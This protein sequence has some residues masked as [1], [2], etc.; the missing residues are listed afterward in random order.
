MLQGY[1]QQLAEAMQRFSQQGTE[2]LASMRTANENSVRAMTGAGESM[3]ESSEQLSRSYQNFV[4]DVVEGLSRALGMFD[5]NM[6]CV[7]AALGDKLQGTS[8]AP[9]AEIVKQL[10]DM[11]RLMTSMAD[12]LKAA[13]DRLPAKEG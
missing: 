9:S 3:Q 11:Q 2:T 13:A 6:S 7:I 8:G 4:T 12:S 5:E 10:G 1:Q